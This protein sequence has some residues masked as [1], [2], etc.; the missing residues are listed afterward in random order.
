MSNIDF[1]A[2]ATSIVTDLTAASGPIKSGITV[3]ILVLSLT[4]GWKLFKRVMK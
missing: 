3:G 4:V 2:T 1:A